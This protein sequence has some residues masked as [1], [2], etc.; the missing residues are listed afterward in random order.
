[1]NTLSEQECIGHGTA[2]SDEICNLYKTTE[3]LYLVRY[4]GAADNSHQWPFGAFHNPRDS[5]DFT[6]QQ[7]PGHGRQVLG[8]FRDADRPVVHHAKS[9]LHKNIT[10]CRQLFSESRVVRFLFRIES[11]ILK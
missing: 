2:N 6:L 10:I 3:Y 7:Q 11:D 8:N 1:L 5:V 9:I 4:L